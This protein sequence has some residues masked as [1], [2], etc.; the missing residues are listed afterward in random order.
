M[1]TY[2]N[3]ASTDQQQNCL[4]NTAFPFAHILHHT[5]RQHAHTH[6]YTH[7]S[8]CASCTSLYVPMPG[9]PP[10]HLS[11]PLP[12]GC[13]WICVCFCLSF[14]KRDGDY[15]WAAR[16]LSCMPID[17]WPTGK[18]GRGKGGREERR[19]DGGVIRGGVIHM[20]LS[21]AFIHL[22]VRLSLA[23]ANVCVCE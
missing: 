2:G 13:E 3:R 10:A 11:S 22:S 20:S 12:A 9:N 7:A 19:A 21:P 5:H 16:I 1:Q 4:L 14:A 18:E 8:A 6:K 17:R 23:R 15:T